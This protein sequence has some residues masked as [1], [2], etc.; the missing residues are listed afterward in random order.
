MTDEFGFQN[1]FLD[2]ERHHDTG[3]AQIWPDG[4][5]IYA[6]HGKYTHAEFADGTKV[7]WHPNGEATE[8]Q[9]EG[10]TAKNLKEELP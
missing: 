1:H 4:S 2:G 3:P 9:G 5:K 8:I 10:E 7:W 6:K